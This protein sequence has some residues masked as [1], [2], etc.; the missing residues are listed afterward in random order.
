M[1]KHL[2]SNEFLSLET[3][4]KIVTK[5][6]KIELSETSRNA[7][8]KCRA[9]LDAKMERQTSPIYGITTGF[10]SLCN[11]SISKE[12]LSQ[13]QHNLVVSHACGF[14]EEVPQEIV[15]L[16]PLLKIQSLSYG[17]SGVQVLLLSV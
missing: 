6:I 16:M 17:N 3:V 14:G 10:G 9:Y 11:T 13:L 7:V 5:K 1:K 4:H 15:K 8:A 12:N 2:I